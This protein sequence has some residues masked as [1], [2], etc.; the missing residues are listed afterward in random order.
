MPARFVKAKNRR[1]HQSRRPQSP[2][3]QSL[4]YLDSLAVES[5]ED[6]ALQAEL[7]AALYYLAA[8]VFTSGDN[9]AANA[10]FRQSLEVFRGVDPNNANVPYLLADLPIV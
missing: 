1:T 6:S 2:V 3:N 8:S 9:A 10:L 4:K 5:T 7:A